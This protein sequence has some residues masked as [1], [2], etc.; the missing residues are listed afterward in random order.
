MACHEVVVATWR[1]THTLPTKTD[2]AGEYLP[3]QIATPN[4]YCHVEV[5]E[6]TFGRNADEHA[7]KPALE[8]TCLQSVTLTSPG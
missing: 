3:V 4:K 5:I 7:L 6:V 2:H 1:K 8:G